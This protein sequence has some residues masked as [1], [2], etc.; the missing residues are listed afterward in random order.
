MSHAVRL[1]VPAVDAVGGED[2]IGLGNAAIN[3]KSQAG[4]SVK[5]CRCLTS[6]YSFLPTATGLHQKKVPVLFENQ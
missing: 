6:T 5:G 4:Q 2:V 1:T 3:H